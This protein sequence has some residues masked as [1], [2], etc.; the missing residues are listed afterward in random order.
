MARPQYGLVAAVA[1]IASCGSEAYSLRTRPHGP[2][3]KDEAS[4]VFTGNRALSRE[5]L[6]VAVSGGDVMST[7]TLAKLVENAY[8]D[9]GLLDVEVDVR[10]DTATGPATVRIER[11]G[12]RYRVGRITIAEADTE[13]SRGDALD[14]RRLR[15]LLGIKAGEWFDRT[16]FT[17][18][19]NRIV[20][21]LRERGHAFALITPITALERE[22]QLVYVHLLI[23]R[24]PVASFGRIDVV[25]NRNIDV[26]RIRRLLLFHEGD[27]YR[28]TSLT[29]SERKLR[30]SGLFEDVS[31]ELAESDT[32]T[33]LVNVTIRVEER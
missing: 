15:D 28:H 19:A 26:S 3:T 20:E 21:R 10:A 32:D 25:G 27:T 31:V 24:G 17:A 22:K 33:R 7:S 11:E 18:G 14:E 30:E 13:I 29:D 23:E 2:P 6:L 1:L 8:Y 5:D 12:E 4:I 16:R 9:A